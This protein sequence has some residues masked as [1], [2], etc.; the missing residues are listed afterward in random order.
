MQKEYD[1]QHILKELQDSYWEGVEEGEEQKEAVSDLLYALILQL[2]E[3]LF[4]IELLKTKEVLKVPKITQVPRSH[5]E[6]LG[7]IN[8]RGHIRPVYDIRKV[9]SLP[10]TDSN[11]STRMIMLNLK[12]QQVG[13]LVDRVLSIHE[14]QKKELQPPLVD[15]LK[16]K[17]QYILGKFYWNR[18]LVLLLDVE[19]VFDSPELA[20]VHL[21]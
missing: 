18:E 2:G 19:N 17:K 4:A 16:L 3:S 7:L 9:L 12:Q 21:E 10:K 5:E 14:L 8:L 20:K 6:L 11:E 13:I 15:D 1:A